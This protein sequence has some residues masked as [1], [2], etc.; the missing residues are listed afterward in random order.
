M[1]ILTF[2]VST[3]FAS[4]RSCLT[5]TMNSN[6]R[7]DILTGFMLLSN[8]SN[9]CVYFFNLLSLIIVVSVISV[10]LSQIL[11]SNNFNRYK[12]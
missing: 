1:G 8:S 11:D 5:F 6:F 9:L 4:L 10:H 3:V 7:T 2:H 12:T